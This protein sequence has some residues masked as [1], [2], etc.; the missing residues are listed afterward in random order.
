[1]TDF[2]NFENYFLIA[3]KIFFIIGSIINLI[4]SLIV[5]KQVS[6]MSKK[7]NDKF[8]YVLT[9]ISYVY[10]AISIVLVLSMIAL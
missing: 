4:F 3:I 2:L 7:I 8:N 6:S 5:V 1:M 10:L 9:I